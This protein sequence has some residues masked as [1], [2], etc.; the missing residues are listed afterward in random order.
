MRKEGRVG[1][2]SRVTKI[3]RGEIKETKQKHQVMR[4]TKMKKEIEIQKLRVDKHS[5]TVRDRKKSRKEWGKERENQIEAEGEEIQERYKDPKAEKKE[6][7]QNSVSF[8]NHWFLKRKKKKKQI[9]NLSHVHFAVMVMKDLGFQFQWVHGERI[10]VVSTHIEKKA[11]ASLASFCLF[12]HS[13]SSWFENYPHCTEEI[14]SGS[15]CCCSV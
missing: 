1:Q 4:E 12:L 8:P 10:E 3:G 5:E 15:S 14:K 2:K 13:F 7:A 9:P 6:K 11:S